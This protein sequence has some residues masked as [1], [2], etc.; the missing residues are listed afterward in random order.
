MKAWTCDIFAVSNPPEDQTQDF[1][2]N[3]FPSILEE[4]YTAATAIDMY[5]DNTRGMKKGSNSL[6]SL[7]MDED[8]KEIISEN[9]GP[10]S[11]KRMLESLTTEECDRLLRYLSR[12]SR[13]N[14]IL[15]TD[16]CYKKMMHWYI[17]KADN[18][19][20]DYLY[21]GFH[22]INR[23]DLANALDEELDENILEQYDKM[24]EKLPKTEEESSAENSK[25][26]DLDED[27]SLRNLQHPQDLLPIGNMSLV[28]FLR[29]LVIALIIFIIVVSCTCCV[30]K[31]KDNIGRRTSESNEGQCTSISDVA[32]I[33]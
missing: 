16:Q 27:N 30:L 8:M 17:T 7:E 1:P 26:D 13:K 28:F 33:P 10:H 29:L 24:K 9:I 3:N 12:P 14:R 20:V 32:T 25:N 4:I 15:T 5:D 31:L 6:N 23:K 19:D 2:S 11:M 22:Y 18:T 21:N